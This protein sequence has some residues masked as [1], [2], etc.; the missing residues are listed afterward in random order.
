VSCPLPGLASKLRLGWKNIPLQ[1]SIFNYKTMRKDILKIAERKLKELSKKYD[2]FIN[3]IVDDWRGFRFIFDTEDVRKCKNDCPN[4]PLFN[5]LKNERK[6]EFSAGL[7]PASKEDKDIFGPQNFLNCKTLD[8][9]QNCYLNYLRSCKSKVEINNELQLVKNMSITYSK[10]KEINEID[11][12][13]E[14]YRKY[15]DFL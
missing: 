14:I 4:C 2:G 3:V 15:L 12:K 9:Y 6:G 10:N 7:Y 13:N 11:F 1:P 5:L 8:Q